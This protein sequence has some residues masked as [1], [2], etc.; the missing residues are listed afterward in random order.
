M[1]S[2][3]ATDRTKLAKLLWLLGSDHQ[4]ERDAAGLAAHRLVQDRGAT[5]FD[6][7]VIPQTISEPRREPP[8]VTLGAIGAPSLLAAINSSI[9]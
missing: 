8:R 4:G 2:L 1:N 3:A 6:V 7:V 9:C 5:W